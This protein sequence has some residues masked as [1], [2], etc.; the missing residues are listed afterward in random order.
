MQNENPKLQP[1]SPA[2]SDHINLPSLPYL[3]IQVGLAGQI[4]MVRLSRAIWLQFGIFIL[5]V[6]Q[7]YSKIGGGVT[8]PNVSFEFFRFCAF[9]LNELC[10]NF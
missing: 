10:K 9:F 4:Y 7:I 3:E 6:M 1:D 5:N 8:E 2:Q